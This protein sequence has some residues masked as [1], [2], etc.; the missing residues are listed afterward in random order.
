MVSMILW[1]TYRF[2]QKFKQEE[3]VKMENFSNAQIELSKT[4][5]LDGNISDLPLKIIQSNNTTP[6][7]IEDSEGNFQSK[8]IDLK[9]N[10]KDQ[11]FDGDLT[12]SDSGLS[13]FFN[14]LIN[15]SEEDMVDFDFDLDLTNADLK[16]FNPNSNAKLS[17]KANVKLRGSKFE[18][19]IGDLTLN[20]FKKSELFF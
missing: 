9:G 3:R 20:N 11:V 2:F 14:G 5:D 4:L 15:F 1:N 12:V 8:N 10:V 7:I 18:H 6:M 13:L 19:L 16:I 17:G